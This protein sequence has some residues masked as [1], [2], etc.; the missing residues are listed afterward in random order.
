M[1]RLRPDRVPPT[2]KTH[3]PPEAGRRELFHDPHLLPL[4]DPVHTTATLPALELRLH[5]PLELVG[6]RV[7]QPTMLDSSAIRASAEDP[8][9]TEACRL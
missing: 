6:I 3:Q 7:E 2:P 1:M 5:L 4:A 9:S 8:Y